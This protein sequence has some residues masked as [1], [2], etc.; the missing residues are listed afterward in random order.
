MEKK[1]AIRKIP[2]QYPLGTKQISGF[3]L[4]FLLSLG[5]VIHGAE[6]LLLYAQAGLM[7]MSGGCLVY[8]L[9]RRKALKAELTLAGSRLTVNGLSITGDSLRELRID[10][11]LVGL[12]PRGKRVVPV[13]LCLDLKD[14]SASLLLLRWAEKQGVPVRQGSFMRW[15]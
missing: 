9:I 8:L 5:N 1:A 6:N 4:L 13:R 10:R 2:V 7:T 3:V 12:L 15:L 11:G 14:R